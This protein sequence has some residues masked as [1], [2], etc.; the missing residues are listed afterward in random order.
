MTNRKD[1]YLKPDV[2]MDLRVIAAKLGSRGY[3]V[4]IE[5][6]LSQ[7]EKS[8][9]PE[10]TGIDLP[11][12]PRSKKGMTR[13]GIALY[14]GTQQKLRVLAA[15]KQLSLGAYIEAVL[16]WLSNEHRE[17]GRLWFDDTPIDVLPIRTRK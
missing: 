11:V 17:H 16:T 9:T 5:D 8:I 14:D 10:T 13:I 7:W 12:L 15:Y 3:T 6:F 2:I 1:I 4:F